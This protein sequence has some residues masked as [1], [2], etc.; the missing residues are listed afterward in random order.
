MTEAI[1]I[2][3]Q[4]SPEIGVGLK[5]QHYEKV[6]ADRPALSFL[7]V[8]AENYMMPGGAHHRYLE[9]IAEQYRLSVHGVGMSLG[10][11]NGLDKDHLTRFRNLVER[12]DPWLVS[13]H[14][15]W[16]RTPGQ[17]LNDL[18][19]LPF[20]KETLDIVAGNVNA[21]QDAVGR[22]ILVENPSSYMAFTT[23][24]MPEEEFLLNLAEATGCG[25][26]LDVNNVYVSGRNMGWNIDDYLRVIP[27]SLIGEIHLAGHLLKDIDGTELR[28]DDHGS[29]VTEPVWNH[30]RKLTERVGAK[31]TLIEWDTDIP[32]LDVLVSEA[33]KAKAILGNLR[34]PEKQMRYA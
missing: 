30:Y 8:H 1:G 20:N 26:L 9:A 23:S 3:E 7:E 27:A 31:P 11:A 29:P 4:S 33:E 17:Y 19:P 16:S 6:L 34:D 25:L 5:A 21:M 13:E 12:Y 10:S 22:Q 2:Q 24:S 15:A 28:I 14:L 32:S 18:L